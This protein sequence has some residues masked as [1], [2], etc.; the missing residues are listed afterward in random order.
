MYLLRLSSI[1][2]TLHRL[3]AMTDVI[4]QW[5]LTSTGAHFVNS[6]FSVSYNTIINIGYIGE[7]CSNKRLIAYVI[8]E[9][10]SALFL[11]N[12]KGPE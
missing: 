7:V 10:F 4:F 12:L 5:H 1:I 6:D 2:K 11:I 8:S 9:K 3:S